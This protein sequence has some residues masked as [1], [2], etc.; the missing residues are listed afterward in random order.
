MPWRICQPE[1]MDVGQ[2]LIPAIACQSPLTPSQACSPVVDSVHS[3][4]ERKIWIKVYIVYGKKEE[5]KPKKFSNSFRFLS[6]TFTYL[7]AQVVFCLFYLPEIVVY[8]I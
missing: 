5:R 1:S 8:F 2:L 6:I 3:Q 7:H 4:I